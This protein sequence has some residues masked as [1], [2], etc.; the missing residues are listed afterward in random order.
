L[1]E[2]FAYQ[3]IEIE[4]QIERGDTIVVILR[5]MGQGLGSGAPIDRR[6]GHVWHVRD[7][8]VVAFE[9]FFDPAA[10]LATLDP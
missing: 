9:W 10:A 2:T 1:G 3:G 6:F 5:F 7:G 4:E 8:K